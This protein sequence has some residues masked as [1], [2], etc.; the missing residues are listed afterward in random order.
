MPEYKKVSCFR[1]ILRSKITPCRVWLSTEA[2]LLHNHCQLTRLIIISIDINA[3]II[4]IITIIII[5]I[6]IIMIIIIF[7]VVQLSASLLSVDWGD[8]W[9]L[10]SFAVNKAIQTI[11]HDKEIM[12]YIVYVYIPGSP[13]FLNIPESQ[14]DS[15]KTRCRFGFE[16]LQ[17]SAS[18]NIRWLRTPQCGKH[19]LTLV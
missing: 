18:Q 4:I 9:T 14:Q 8:S 19:H 11:I 12:K 3:I 16:R 5:I 15:T 13:Y 6:I 2:K 17:L 7:I 1:C 10:K